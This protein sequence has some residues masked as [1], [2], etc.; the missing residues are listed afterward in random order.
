MSLR[1]IFDEPSEQ[2]TCATLHTHLSQRSYHFLTYAIFNGTKSMRLITLASVYVC[3]CGRSIH[4]FTFDVSY[5]IG[6]SIYYVTL[7]VLRSLILFL[8][9]CFLS[10]ACIFAGCVICF[11]AC[12][13]H[14][15]FPPHSKTVAVSLAD[16]QV[17]IASK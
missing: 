11:T 16:R 17:Q 9:L 5:N 15:S 8:S 3:V 13:V 10:L 7:D 6:I 4:W 1:G 2:Q 12:F 14:S